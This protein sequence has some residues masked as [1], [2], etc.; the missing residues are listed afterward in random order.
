MNEYRIYLLLGAILVMLAFVIFGSLTSRNLPPEK[1]KFHVRKFTLIGLAVL[2]FCLPIFK[3]F[4]Y[5][6]SQA[7]H[8]ETKYVGKLDSIEQVSE[9]QAKQEKDIRLLKEDVME[10]KEDLYQ[11]FYICFQ[12]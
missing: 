4:V 1:R 7:K 6:Y 10:L 3:P 12:R 8:I 11:Q 2:L 5:S 9:Y